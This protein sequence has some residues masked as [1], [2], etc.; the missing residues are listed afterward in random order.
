M[1]ASNENLSTSDSIPA[2]MPDK[3]YQKPQGRVK[4][5]KFMDTE[6]LPAY[7][8]YNPL[9]W[10]VYTGA[11]FCSWI[12]MLSREATAGLLI[13]IFAVQ[14]LQKGLAQSYISNSISFYFRDMGGVRASQMQI[15]ISVIMTPWALKGLMGIGSDALA[16]GGYHK[17][18]YMLLTAVGAILA[19][20]AIGTTPIEKMTIGGAIM[21]LFI[22]QL[23]IALNDLLIEAK[24]SEKIQ[25]KPAIN[26]DLVSYV[27][28]GMSCMSLLAVGT[29]GLVIE[30][31]GAQ[32]VYALCCL[33]I[34]LGTIPVAMNMMNDKRIERGSQCIHWDSSI[35]TARGE[36]FTYLAMIVTA[37]GLGLAFSGVFY[38]NIRFNLVLALMC[39][40][41]TI[42]GFFRYT[43][44]MIAKVNAFTLIQTLFSMSI[45]GATFY[46][47]TDGPEQ[48]PEGPHFSDWFYT[49]AIGLV[50]SG[51]AILGIF[52]FNRYLGNMNYRTIFL[53]SSLVYTSLSLVN[54]IVFLRWN[55][56]WGLSDKVFVLGSAALQTV[57][58]EFNY[59]PAVMIMSRLCPKGF[60]ATMFALLASASNLGANISNYSGAFLLDVMGVRPSGA[61]NESEQFENLWLVALI[62]SVLPCLPLVLLPYLIPDAC[63][64]DEGNLIEEENEPAEDGEDQGLLPR[65][66]SDES[67]AGSRAPGSISIGLAEE[68]D[69]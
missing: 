15:Y 18:P 12:R 40:F 62:T 24:Y 26:S 57:I 25:E 44:P 1:V 20:F 61:A 64:S 4:M 14:H 9:F 39:G 66:E 48:Y 29:V 34:F 42:L 13:S 22:G 7:Y 51:T 50:A 37:L 21:C 43:P 65:E 58:K 17:I 35:M 63:P 67:P 6:N 38:D 33:P 45:E 30:T 5:E 11:Y 10:L 49:T 23:H 54:I 36:D 52:L 28:G 56:A 27:W 59:M 31:L 2:G 68:E 69:V 46:F 60:E 47:F 3:K 19:L 32:S 53:W 55:K 8:K 16:I 41:I